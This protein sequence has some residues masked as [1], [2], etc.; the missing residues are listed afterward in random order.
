M[1]RAWLGVALDPDSASPLALTPTSATQVSMFS[2][3]ARIAST[4]RVTRSV[5][6][7]SVPWGSW[8]PT[9]AWSGSVS[10]KNSRPWFSPR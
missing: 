1:I 3:V 2:C 10:G 4:C 8:I 9:M 5:V 7:T 6:S